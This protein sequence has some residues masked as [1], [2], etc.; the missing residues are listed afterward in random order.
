MSGIDYI[1]E[2]G[3]GER[4][5]QWFVTVAHLSKHCPDLAIIGFELVVVVPHKSAR[6]TVTEAGMS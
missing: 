2:G 3:E 6:S 5:A 1:G 4:E